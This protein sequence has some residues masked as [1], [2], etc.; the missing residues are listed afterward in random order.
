MNATAGDLLDLLRTGRAQTRSDLRTLTGLSR[1]AV[2][3]RVSALADAGLLILGEEL[4]STG[5]RR[6]GSLRFDVDAAMVLSVAVGRSRSQLAAFDLAGKELGGTSVEH[7]E[8][9]AP[10]IVMRPVAAQLALLVA[11]HARP[12]LGV[13]VSLPGIVDPARGVSIDSPVIAAWDGVDLAP[14]LTTVTGAPLH[15]GNDADVLALSERLGHATAYDDL[16]VLKASTGLGLGIVSDGR[17]V[18]GHLGG[19]GE[20][21]HVRIA[22]AAGLPCRCGAQ[23]CLETLAAGWSLVAQS[24]DAGRPVNHIRELTSLA[25]NGD[26]QAKALL[27]DSGRRVG[28]VLATAVTLLNPHALVIGGDMAAAFDVY[29]AGVRE[30]VYA[31]ATAL[32]T[33]DLQVL[34]STYGDRAGIVGCAVMA[35]DAALAP[36]SIDAML[37]AGRS[38]P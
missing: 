24:G 36:S 22:D 19:A 17:V 25:V 28:E 20:I 11:Q 37:E 3:S 30:S 6:P 21:G 29:A 5:G 23:G 1:T 27:R 7:E 38:V 33:R 15:V 16:L 12:V 9:A 13:G 10:D 34:P 8:G 31:N 26:P 2:V 14:Y 18:D 35:L 32:A 4:A